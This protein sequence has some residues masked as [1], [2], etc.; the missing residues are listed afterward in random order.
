MLLVAAF[1]VGGHA[2][3]NEI[4]VAKLLYIK[5]QTVYLWQHFAQQGRVGR[6]A[7]YG[8]RE[9][10]LLATLWLGHVA[11]NVLVLYALVRGL[12][13]NQYK[14]AAYGR[15]DVAVVQ[16]RGRAVGRALK[17]PLGAA[18]HLLVALKVALNGYVALGGL[19]YGGQ[20][21]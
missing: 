10:Q 9:K 11:Y 19:L 12:L 16:L 14:A 15:N 1:K 3:Y 4:V 6:G 13:V 7:L 2:V 5:P 20:L 21:V 18:L 17:K 8:G